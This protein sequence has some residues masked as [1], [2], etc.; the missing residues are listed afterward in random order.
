MS[1][2]DWRI[3]PRILK[4]NVWNKLMQKYE[5]NVPSHLAKKFAMKTFPQKLRSFKYELLRG[6]LKGK[7]T[8]AEKI[9]ACPMHYILDHWKTFL[10][11]ESDPAVKKKHTKCG[12]NLKNKSIKHT[13]T[14]ISYANKCY[15]LGSTC[16]HIFHPFKSS[17]VILV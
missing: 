3:V 17:H 4:E 8:M 16:Y 6:P 10:L 11:H 2:L 5:F 9:D 13:L 14:R 15:N 12:S 1:F 7:V